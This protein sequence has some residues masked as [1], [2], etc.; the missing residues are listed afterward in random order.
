MVLF[1]SSTLYSSSQTI[2]GGDITDGLDL[3]KVEI[4]VD[5][6][7]T[8]MVFH[9]NYWEGYTNPLANTPSDTTGHYIFKLSD[10]N[11]SIEAIFSGFRSASFEYPDTNNTIIKSITPLIGELYN[12]DSSL[13]YQIK[14]RKPIGIKVFTLENPTRI[15]LYSQIRV[16]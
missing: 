9:I 16:L 8:R 14:L 13:S 11:L 3:S 4:G 1:L 5:D 2:E 10:D 12:D 15:I 6:K 7:Y